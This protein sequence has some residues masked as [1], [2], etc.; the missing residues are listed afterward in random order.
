MFFSAL[1]IND[2]LIMSANWYEFPIRK[3]LVVGDSNC[4]KTCLISSFATNKFPEEYVPRQFG[5]YAG[6][7]NV[8]GKTVHLE[9][10]DTIGDP[11]YDRYRPLSYTQTDVIVMC[12]SIDSPN[13]LENVVEMWVPEMSHFCPNIPIILVGNKKD[14]RDDQETKEKLLKFGQAA[15]TD[16]EGRAMCERI[17]GYAYM[18]CSAKTLDGVRDVFETAARVALTIEPP[19]P[20]LWQRLRKCS[21]L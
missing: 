3:M 4:G 20:R 19:K 18:E 14:L 1:Q 7:I 11:I 15:V 8:D 6:R 10:F 13:S 21:V 2:S 9:F 5:P 12:F 17:N 16:G